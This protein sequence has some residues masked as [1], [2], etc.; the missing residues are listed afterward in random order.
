MPTPET[1]I[2]QIRCV[3]LNGCMWGCSK[4]CGDG[5]FELPIEERQQRIKDR[6]KEEHPHA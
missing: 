5:R 2:G 4:R 3:Y 1:T 6:M